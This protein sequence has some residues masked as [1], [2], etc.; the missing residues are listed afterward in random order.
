MKILIVHNKY[1]SNYI[2]GEDLV[3]KD[4]VDVLRNKLG[5]NN[6]VFY[7]VSNDTLSSTAL[8]KLSYQMWFSWEH[9]YKIRN[10]IR[11]R[12]I[13]IVHVHNYFP[14]LTP[15]IFKAAKE[16]GCKVIHTLHNYRLWCIAGTF[17]RNDYGICEVCTKKKFPLAGFFN[18]CYRN[19]YLHSL[20]AQLAFSFYRL[21]NQFKYID[22]FFVLTNFQLEKVKSLGIEENKIKLKPNGIR[23]NLVEEIL[24]SEVNY[25]NKTDYI[26]VGR[27]EESKG[28]LQ[29]LHIWEKLDQRFILHIVGDG[30]LG[31]V[32]KEKHKKSM[33]IIFHGQQDRRSTLKKISLSRYLIFPSIW[34]ETFGLVIIESM[35]LKTPVI[36]FSIGTRTELIRHEFNGFLCDFS[37]L[38][39]TLKLSFDYPHYRDLCENSRQF[40]EQYILENI[41]E[42]QIEFYKNILGDH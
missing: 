19:S 3:Y 34:Y 41:I 2:G 27:L 1:L 26:F 10:I 42:A 22:Y 9:Y 24:Q 11:E 33:N 18:R 29:L 40:G 6:V 17:F 4:E 35:L 13:K 31:S 37:S 32:L 16:C 28:I 36:G 7:E 23:R 15:S 5:S 25:V 8:F 30:P 38:E 12:D 39:L 20:T 14:I 21:S